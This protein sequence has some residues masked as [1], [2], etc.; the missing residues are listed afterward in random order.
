MTT[1]ESIS[2]VT[3][4]ETKISEEKKLRPCCV[5][6]D[7]RQTRDDCVFYNGEEKCSG[8][9][10]AHKKCLRAHGFKI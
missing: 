6:K 10:E 4:P 1:T 3:E 9:I 2:M 7:T 8:F 5:C